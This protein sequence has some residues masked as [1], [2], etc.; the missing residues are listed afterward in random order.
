MHVALAS[1]PGLPEDTQQTLYASASMLTLPYLGHRFWPKPSNSIKVVIE[2][3]SGLALAE[4]L[5]LSFIRLFHSF[6]NSLRLGHRILIT[7]LPGS[8][9]NLSGCTPSLF[10]HIPSAA[11]L[12]GRS[13]SSHA[14]SSSSVSSLAVLISTFTKAQLR[15]WVPR[16]F[17]G[18]GDRQHCTSSRLREA[19]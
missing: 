8:S 9:Q 7:N 3:V 2:G 6:K 5:F 17:E 12:S 1:Y 18:A 13:S 10:V 4:I 15:L 11:N 16:L 19:L 14:Q